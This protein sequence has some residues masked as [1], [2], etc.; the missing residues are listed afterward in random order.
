[1]LSMSE[2]FRAGHGGQA[3]NMSRLLWKWTVLAAGTLA[4]GM[5]SCAPTLLPLHTTVAPLKLKKVPMTAALVMPEYLKNGVSTQ[6]VSCAGNYNVL[7][8]NELETGMTEALSQVFD[9][10]DVVN[11]KE[12]ALGHYDV[13]VEPKALQLD[14]EGHCLSRRLLYLTL[15]F[16]VFFSPTDSFDGHAEVPVTVMDRQGQVLLTDTFKSKTHT[17]D[18]LFQSTA[19]KDSAVAI[20]L[21]ESATEVFQQIARGLAASS[22]LNT[23]AQKL[24]KKPADRAASA[25]ASIDRFSDVD[26]LPQAAAKSQKTRYAV[27]IGIER[28]RQNLPSV[29]FA[30]HDAAIMRDY[31]TKTLGYPNENVV[32]LLNEQAAK[33]D[34]EKYIERWLPNRVDKDSSILV[35]Y[36]GHGAPNPSTQE[37]YLVPYDG[38]PTF[39]EITGYSLKRLYEQLGKLPA[40]EVLVVLDSCFSGS[41]GRSV[42][43]KGARPLV[44]SIE[45]P[46]LAGDKIVVLTA[47]SASQISSTYDQKNHGLFTYFFLKGIQSA[48]D[49]KKDGRIDLSELYAYVKPQVEGVARREYNNDQIPQLIGNPEVLKRGMNLLDRVKP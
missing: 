22:Q 48:A 18:A 16:Y 28:Y 7:I 45:N 33:S 5:Q 36:S 47:S 2:R 1:M 38:D 34:V 25:V 13:L 12:A 31:L 49:E 27:V 9:G 3:M 11:N 29:E 40:R 39:L 6:N 10:M 14:A 8:G 4:L 30:S 17:K 20:V 43:A 35:Y 26:I 32:T 24:P 15:I 46:L 41:G 23:Y 21:Q 42:I 37:G 19:D 44:V